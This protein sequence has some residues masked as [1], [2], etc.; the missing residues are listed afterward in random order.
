MSHRLAQ[1]ESTL[2]RA[3]ADVLQRDL[4]DPRV[5]GLISITKLKVSPDLS[6]AYVN[7]SILPEEKQ[8]RVV[9]GLQHAAGHIQRLTRKRVALKAVPR[10]EFRLDE[11]LK[12]QATVEQAIVEAMQRTGPAE[13]AEGEAGQSESAQGPGEPGQTEQDNQ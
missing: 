3:I 2:Q 11:G 1:I 7:V 6:Q 8:A 13:S 12:R 10:L 9:Q 4:A 5:E